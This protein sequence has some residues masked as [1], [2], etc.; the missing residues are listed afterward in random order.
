MKT[1]INV[2][3]LIFGLLMIASGV[4]L[5]AF[6]MNFLPQEYKTV[7]FSWPMLIFAIGFSML[8]SSSH[9]R[10]SLFL[11]LVGILF[12]FPKLQRATGSNLG[13]QDNW[14]VI[15]VII[16]FVFLFKS[17]FRQY[18]IRSHRREHEHFWNSRVKWHDRMKEQ[19]DR[20]ADTGYINR[21]YVFGGVREK[22]DMQAFKGGDINCVFGGIE[23]DLSDSKLA[24][25][26]HTLE[27][28]TVFGGVNIYIPVDWKIEIRQ[29]QMFGR[30]VDNRPMPNFEINEN[31][32][33]VM[34]VTSVF[35]GGEIRCK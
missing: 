4:C 15:L 31:N 26:V 20:R 32:L 12:L 13:T 30:F 34:E 3:S 7:V 5:F 8:F 23:L 35:G 22:I 16:G 1:K 21:N 28:N 29:D 33:L 11:M 24:E 10:F 17:L 27:I 2:C 14:P 9:K 18:F 6:N 19:W 25:G